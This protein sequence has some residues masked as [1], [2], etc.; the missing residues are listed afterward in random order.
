MSV[1]VPEVLTLCEHLSLCPYVCLVSES[2][3]VCLSL[4]GCVYSWPSV[5]AHLC[6][7]LYVSVCV[8]L[9]QCI[10]IKVYV[11]LGSCVWPSWH[12]KVGKK[13]YLATPWAILLL[14]G[15]GRNEGLLELGPLPSILATKPVRLERGWGQAKRGPRLSPG[16]DPRLSRGWWKQ[17]G[18]LACMLLSSS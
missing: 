15:L 16:P 10:C 1:H 12:A 7:Y 4:L 14:R 9:S 3:S 5:C 11:S 2:I 8:C 17:Q 6:M 13:A 18:H